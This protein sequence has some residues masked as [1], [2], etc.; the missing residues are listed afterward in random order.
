QESRPR[1]VPLKASARESRRRFAQSHPGSRRQG[2][3]EGLLS[4]APCS[5]QLRRLPVRGDGSDDLSGRRRVSRVLALQ[6]NEDLG[7]GVRRGRPVSQI[8][9]DLLGALNHESNSDIFDKGTAVPTAVIAY[10]DLDDAWARRTELDS[11]TRSLRMLAGIDDRFQH[12]S[13]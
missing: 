2:V 12:D 8:A 5:S 6:T 3:L 11:D 7:A 4:P 1:T 9:G 10:G 13:I